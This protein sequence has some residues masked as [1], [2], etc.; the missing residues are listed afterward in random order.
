MK[1]V[2]IFMLILLSLFSC[3][4]HAN[5]NIEEIKINTQ[6]DIEQIYE[7]ENNRNVLEDVPVVDITLDVENIH[8]IENIRDFILNDLG[9]NRRFN[10]IDE[11]VFILNI[12]NNYEIEI[13]TMQNW[14]YDE[15]IDYFYY[16]E[17]EQYNIEL[18]KNEFFIEYR[19]ISFEIKINE[20]NYLNIFPYLTMDEYIETNDFDKIKN[21]KDNIIEYMIDTESRNEY[22]YLIFEN[23]ILKSF[24]IVYYFT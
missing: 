17:S 9:I 7:Y 5:N 19:I 16:I 8:S 3:I 15:V 4:K 13:K 24:R 1:K 18:F 12:I 20:N 22:C 11:L 23:D 21:I 6:K 2:I 10:S 14:H